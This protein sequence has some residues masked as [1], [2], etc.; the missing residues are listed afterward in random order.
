MIRAAWHRILGL[1]YGEFMWMLVGVMLLVYELWAV[2]TRGGDVLTR[3]LRA[4]APRWT[5]VPV[6]LGILMGHLT[7]PR[8]SPPP[9]VWIVPFTVLAIALCRDLLVGT[10][11]AYYVVTALFLAGYVLG[12]LWAGRP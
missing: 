6:G 11:V 1:T 3:A 5:A 2:A 4:N 12:N 8:W 7:G 9:L 10:R